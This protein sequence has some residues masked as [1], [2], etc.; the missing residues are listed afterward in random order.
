ASDIKV[1]TYVS[2][3]VT[4]LGCTYKLIPNRFMPEDR[5]Y[6]F[7]AADWTQMVLRA[8][9]TQLLAKTGS[10]D[11]YMIEMEVGLRHKNQ[12]ASGILEITAGTTPSITAISS[13]HG[14]VVGSTLD[15]STLFTVTG[16]GTPTFSVDASGNATLGAD[17]KTLTGVKV[18]D[19]VV[20]GTLNGVTATA[21]VTIHVTAANVAVASV[22]VA[23][24]TLTKVVG[25]AAVVL[26][27]TVLPANASNKAVTWSSSDATVAA[28]NAT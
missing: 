1:N 6:F 18:G 14:L 27:A 26:T 23:P 4:P 28:V 19:T 21:T 24:T 2:T 22:T 15:A 8:P 17:G 11:K 16:G 13:T 3:L 12:F 9:T 25:D 5:I 7:R 20:T 10:H